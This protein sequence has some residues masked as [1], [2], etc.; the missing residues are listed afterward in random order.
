MERPMIWGFKTVI[1]SAF[2]IWVL[3]TWVRSVGQ[4]S[5]TLCINT[6]LKVEE[7]SFRT[8][9]WHSVHA[10]MAVAW[11][12]GFLHYQTVDHNAVF[13][14]HGTKSNR[15]KEG[16]CGLGPF[17]LFSGSWL[18]ET[19]CKIPTLLSNLRL[20]EWVLVFILNKI[21]SHPYREC[22]WC[23]L[24]YHTFHTSYTCKTI[25]VS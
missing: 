24:S 20:S 23:S 15:C 4:N 6:P 10:P 19:P 8:F 17:L 22:F 1:I 18:S 25:L 2:L 11:V 3:I 16:L 13:A 9:L 14:V 12:C 5:Q 7:K 21:F